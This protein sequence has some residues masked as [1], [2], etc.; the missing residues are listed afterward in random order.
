M[1]PLLD[2]LV[3]EI[4]P[5]LDRPFGIFGHSLGAWI[6][7][8]LA[9]RLRQQGAPAPKRLFVSACRAPHL[10]GRFPPIHQLP[11]GPLLQEIQRRYGGL[12]SLILDDREVLQQ[13]L[14]VLRADLALFETTV[15]AAEAPLACPIT[16]LGGQSDTIVSSTDL[17]AW[18]E[19]TAH[20]AFHF[21]SFP[22]SHHYIRDLPAGLLP[23]I[24]HGLE[25]SI[26]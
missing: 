18:S 16:A 13:F 17:E 14:R 8:G 19:H 21:R 10:P 9:R 6:G 1:E 11:D 7:F 24:A 15:F 4:L 3:P 2:T 22:G 12:P 23:G 20:P 5:F 26:P 25:V